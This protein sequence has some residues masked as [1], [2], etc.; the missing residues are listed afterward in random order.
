MQS[1]DSVLSIKCMDLLIRRENNGAMPH[2]LN[3][4]V[5][6]ESPAEGESEA[7]RATD[8]SGNGCRNFTAPTGWTGFTVSGGGAP[9]ITVTIGQ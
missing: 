3:D 6:P 9:A 2:A 5:R 8:S 1:R 4:D 7:L